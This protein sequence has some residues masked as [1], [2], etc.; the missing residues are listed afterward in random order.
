MSLRHREQRP[1]LHHRFAGA[2]EDA[3]ER[4]ELIRRALGIRGEAPRAFELQ[5]A[6]SAE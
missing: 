2:A 4:A 3:R 5:G 6:E 1:Q